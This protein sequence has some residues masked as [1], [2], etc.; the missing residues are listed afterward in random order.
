MPDGFE[1]WARR[2]LLQPGDLVPQLLVLK[3]QRFILQFE[4]LNFR[5]QVLVLGPQNS[6]FSFKLVHLSDQTRNQAAHCS[7]R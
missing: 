4:A 1:R 6:D 3:P 7:E 5:A 2:Q